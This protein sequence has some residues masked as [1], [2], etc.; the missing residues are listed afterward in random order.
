MSK[1]TIALIQTAV[2]E[3]PDHNLKHALEMAGSAISKGARI[4]CL[5]ELYRAPYFPQYEDADASAYAETIPGASTEAF[6]ALAREHGAVFILPI[7]ERA[8]SGEH[9][10]SA[11][12]VDADGRVLFPAYQK[13]H[14]HQDPPIYDKRY[15]HAGDRYR[16]YDTR[17]GRIAVLIS[18]DQ[19][20]PEAAR[21]VALR[22]AE[23]IF[24]PSAIG[25]IS[26]ERSPGSDWREAWETVQRGHAIANGLHIAA[27]NRVGEDGC[28]RFFGSS[29]IADAFG[30]VIAR[31]SEADEEVLIAEVDPSINE[32]A[33]ERWNLFQNRRPETYRALIRK[34]LPGKTPQ[35]LGYR[36]PA[37]WEPH[38]AVWLAWPYDREMLPDLAAVEWNYVEIIAAL[39]RSETVNLLVTGE[40]MRTRVGGILLEGGIDASGVRF[41]MLDYA[42]VWLRDYGPMFVVNRR[43]ESLAMVHWNFNAW[44]EKYP[45]LKKD[46][47]VPLMMN[48]DLNLPIFTP[49]IVL[50]GSS[51]EVNGA[52]TA[53]VTESCLMNPNRNPRSAREDIEA[54]LEAY[55]GV[56]H[57]IWLKEGIA[58]DETGG[59]VDNIARFV[60]PTTVLCVIEDDRDDENYAPLKE[61]YEILRSSTDQDGKPLTVIPLPTPGRVGGEVRLPASYANF[62]IG[63]TVVLVPTFKHPNDAPALARIRQAFPGRKVIGIDCTALVEG[64]GGVHCITLQQPSISSGVTGQRAESPSRKK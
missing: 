30:N 54:Y 58:G 25:W 33:R 11:V 24:Y 3:D 26:G 9:Y 64:M 12:V 52:G 53:I 21:A 60:N 39:R 10:N 7:Y 63:N 31:A 6:S 17:Y 35:A 45:D 46:S 15:F 28:I 62:Y 55:L 29:F 23:M 8:A 59:H 61:N 50:E 37:E 48:R 38:D 40:Q 1:Q 13:V 2:S 34:F 18:Y 27:V 19:W 14:I 47:E 56:S 44:G 36:M 41:H 51:V 5:P 32:A 43:T 42:D 16:L 49:G 57:V 20:F 4:I 22:G